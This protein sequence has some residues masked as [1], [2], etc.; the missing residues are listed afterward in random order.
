[1]T[2]RGTIL[3]KG[4]LPA[5]DLTARSD[6]GGEEDLRRRCNT[7]LIQIRRARTAVA[8]PAAIKFGIKGQLPGRLRHLNEDMRRVDI[9]LV[10]ILDDLNPQQSF[11]FQDAEAQP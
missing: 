8:D 6:A 10:A 7:W 3:I 11:R 9:D 4:H 2:Y 5:S 1:L